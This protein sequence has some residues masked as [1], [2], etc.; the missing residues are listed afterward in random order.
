MASKKRPLRVVQLYPRQMNIYGDN[1]NAQIICRRA[2]LYGYDV[3]L[4]AYNL[5]E[6][7]KILLSA[8]I[9]LG[10]GGQDSGQRAI[11][12]DLA[13]IKPELLRLAEDKVPMLMI[14]G[15]YQLFGHYF[16][17]NQGDRLNGIGLFDMV[18]V[19]GDKRLIGNIVISND[20][21]GEIIGYENHSGVTELGDSQSALGVV[22]SGYGNDSNSLNEGAVRYRTV[23][24][25]LHGPILAKNPKLADWIIAGAVERTFGDCKLRAANE[26]CSRKL[27]MLDKSIEFARKV[28][29]NRPQ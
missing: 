7:S 26:R 18:T 28:A 15:M 19:G 12:N 20:Q 21:L 23:G 17:T 27:A 3:E 2:E 25:Y 5:I 22:V 6:D 13:K 4:G 16:E 9:V 1:G 14:C 8:D 29:K 10:G 11:V 24:S